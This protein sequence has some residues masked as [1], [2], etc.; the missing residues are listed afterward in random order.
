MPWFLTFFVQMRLEGRQS[1][2]RHIQTRDSA[3]GEEYGED[4]KEA[5][6]SEEEEWAGWE[7]VGG[8]WKRTEG[9]WEE[10]EAVE[11]RLTQAEWEAR[12]KAV[13]AEAKA[14]EEEAD[15]AEK[16]AEEEER[17]V[18][19]AIM[20]KAATKAARKKARKEERKAEAQEAKDPED[21]RNREQQ[22]ANARQKA[23]EGQAAAIAAASAVARKGGNSSMARKAAEK[24]IQK[25]DKAKKAKD[26]ATTL[27][28]DDI[29][30]LVSERVE[31]QM[32]AIMEKLGK[33]QTTPATSKRHKSPKA[34]DPNWK[35]VVPQQEHQG[36]SLFARTQ[37]ILVQI[38]NKDPKAKKVFVECRFAINVGGKKPEMRGVL[39]E[40][41]EGPKPDE[42]TTPPTFKKQTRLPFVKSPGPA[43]PTSTKRKLDHSLTEGQSKMEARVPKTKPAIK[44]R[45]KPKTTTAT[46]LEA[47][48][49]LTAA[50]KVRAAMKRI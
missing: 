27:T 14:A 35:R 50:E 18:E 22:K 16:R 2:R 46:A 1:P 38:H 26:T 7:K 25:I 10:E 36:Y 4:E 3:E 12:A 15:Q 34:L 49:P 17:A 48:A 45:K 41:I 20:A 39:E 37:P 32:A 23:A 31:K 29:D 13:K 28:V 44:E 47:K 43:A 6:E 42:S 5:E 30:R 19:E 24:A 21:T 40:D 8:E 11:E 9:V 33:K